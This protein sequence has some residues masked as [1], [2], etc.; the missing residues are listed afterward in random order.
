MPHGETAYAFALSSRQKWHLQLDVHSNTACDNSVLVLVGSVNRF[1][2]AESLEEAQRQELA[3]VSFAM[4]KNV[5]CCS[6]LLVRDG[7]VLLARG[8][9]GA[10]AAKSTDASTNLDTLSS[11]V[12]KQLSESSEASTVVA[13]SASQLYLPDRGAMEAAGLGGG[14][15]IPAGVNSLMLAHLPGMQSGCLM[16]LSDRARGL[17]DKDRNWAVAMAAKLGPILSQ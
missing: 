16:V 2:V 13:G 9:L 4:L 6:L 14:S 1:H 11:V 3:W 10:E 12:S 17:S 8:A 7:K 5:N 15:S